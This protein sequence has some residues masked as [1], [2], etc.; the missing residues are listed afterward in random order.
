MRTLTQFVLMAGGGSM[1][2][3]LEERLGKEVREH[4]CHFCSLVP[5]RSLCKLWS[6]L[7][8]LAFVL[9]SP[10]FISPPKKKTTHT[11]IHTHTHDMRV[12]ATTTTARAR[13]R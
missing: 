9:A 12:H 7:P 8:L 6:S 5:P 13:I 4:S 1:F 10:I 2:P 11:H 3:G